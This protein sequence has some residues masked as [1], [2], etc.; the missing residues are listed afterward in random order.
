[1]VDPSV[2]SIAHYGSSARSRLTGHIFR[3]PQESPAQR[4][5]YTSHSD[6]IPRVNSILY[7]SCLYCNAVCPNGQQ[8]AIGR[9]RQCREGCIPECVRLKWQLRRVITSCSRRRAIG[10]RSLSRTS[11][12]A[13]LSSP[14]ESKSLNA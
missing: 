11:S 2:N 9:L 7:R 6:F 10:V 13:G 1:M 5:I 8:S 14:R 4:S 3:A 12:S